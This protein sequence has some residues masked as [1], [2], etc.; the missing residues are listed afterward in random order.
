M[1]WNVFRH[2]LLSLYI[3]TVCSIFAQTVFLEKN[4]TKQ[5]NDNNNKSKHN[6]VTVCETVT[7][8]SKEGKLC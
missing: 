1:R 7:A 2:I 5:N 8:S 4:K 3:S 6:S